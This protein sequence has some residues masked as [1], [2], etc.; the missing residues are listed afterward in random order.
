MEKKKNLY[1]EEILSIYK[2][3]QQNNVEERSKNKSILNITIIKENLIADGLN[4]TTL[5]LMDEIKQNLSD[6]EFATA[7]YQQQHQTTTYT[8]S[9]EEDNVFSRFLL[10]SDPQPTKEGG[11]DNI[12]ETVIFKNIMF[13]KSFD[14]LQFQ[15]ESFDEVYIDIADH[16]PIEVLEKVQIPKWIQWVKVGGELFLEG[17]G[18][19]PILKYLFSPTSPYAT[20]SII[21]PPNTVANTD[22][23]SNTTNTTDVGAT[24]GLNL[25]RIGLE[26]LFSRKTAL[27]PELLSPTL[28]KY[29]IDNIMFKEN[30][31]RIVIRGT[32]IIS[33]K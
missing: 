27:I 31:V 2:N 11:N 17:N 6:K 15:K 8:E 5:D 19:G 4:V 18:L 20:A 9:E 32:K 26:L 25:M 22:S 14:N 10:L 29:G 12:D 13:V 3:L 30:G 1:A 28:Q 24:I 23:I 21:P 16:Y 7:T 33:S